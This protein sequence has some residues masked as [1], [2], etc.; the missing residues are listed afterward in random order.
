MNKKACVTLNDFYGDF[1]G[2]CSSLYGINTVVQFFIRL[3]GGRTVTHSMGA[4]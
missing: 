1:E 4:E 2:F 3:C